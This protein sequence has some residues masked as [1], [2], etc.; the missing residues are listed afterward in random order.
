M[1]A[2][3][4]GMMLTAEKP[5][6]ERRGALRR[7]EEEFMAEEEPLLT[8]GDVLKEDEPCVTDGD[9]LEEVEPILTDVDTPAEA[10]QHVTDA[11]TPQGA[12]N[13][14]GR[15]AKAKENLA[16]VWTFIST[17]V[18]ACIVIVALA[19]VAVKVSGCYL[20]TIE[21]ASMAPEYPVDTVVVVRPYGSFAEIQVGD[22][23]TY[24]MNE[25]GDTVTHRV[26]AIDAAGRTVTTQGDANDTADA[27]P[28]LYG[29][30]V[31]EVVY[32]IPKVGR[33][34]R[35]ITDEDNR[36]VIIAVIAALLIWGFAWDWV[37]GLIRRRRAQ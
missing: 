29:N 18:I 10:D 16:A 27:T 19:L 13:A 6:A 23:V 33:V 34:V 37:R 7:P 5:A 21:T 30:V 36:A 20:F 2:A 1:I 26:V 12:D 11:Q 31:G 22:V 15:H 32:S 28:V 24:V 25:A 14:P 9:V 8:E 17:F 35:V 4:P 3:P